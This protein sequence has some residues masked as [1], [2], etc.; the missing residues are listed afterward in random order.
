M[1]PPPALPSISFYASSKPTSSSSNELTSQ[2]VGF[3]KYKVIFKE[4]KW[5]FDHSFT[6]MTSSFEVL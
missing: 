6:R 1:S 2:G 4:A 3:W 5:D